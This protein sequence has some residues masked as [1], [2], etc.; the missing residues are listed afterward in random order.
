MVTCP[1]CNEEN[2]NKNNCCA[3][4]GSRIRPV[5]KRFEQDVLF[6]LGES[7]K[8]RRK[9]IIVVAGLVIGVLSY[10]GHSWIQQTIATMVASQV[11]SLKPT[12]V[13]EA[14]ARAEDMVNREV[15]IAMSRVVD[16][17]SERI[18]ENV[19]TISDQRSQRVEKIYADAERDARA[20]T[21]QLASRFQASV[22]D[23][24]TSRRDSA[25][26]VF[27]PV[28]VSADSLFPAQNQ[29]N[30]GLIDV[31]ASIS[32]L[33]S[34]ETNPFTIKAPSESTT[35]ST[36]TITHTTYTPLCIVGVP[37]YTFDKETG[38]LRAGKPDDCKDQLVFNGGDLHI[39]PMKQ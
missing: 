23:I 28:G 17:A 12:I 35:I 34:T 4:C 6:V 38:M 5:A 13:K 19:R 3:N 31:S 9:G 36:S 8:S 14:T 16:K 2:A 27:T 24:Q 22:G 39:T 21:K 26:M 11:E 29:K 37:A 18:A 15:P 1:S 30:Y 10:F 33:P 32:G 20:E 25:T 7:R